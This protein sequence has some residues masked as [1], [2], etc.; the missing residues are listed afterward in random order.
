MINNRTWKF[1]I[2]SQY[3]EF[4]FLKVWENKNIFIIDACDHPSFSLKLSWNYCDVLSNFEMLCQPFDIIINVEI[5]VFVVEFDHCLVFFNLDNFA[6]LTFE[7]SFYQ[8]DFISRRKCLYCDSKL[9]IL[10]FFFFE[11]LNTFICN[12]INWILRNSKFSNCI[13]VWNDIFKFD[14]FEWEPFVKEPK[15]VLL[16]ESVFIS[17]LSSIKLQ[18]SRRSQISRFVFLFR[19]FFFILSRDH[20]NKHSLLF[21]VNISNLSKVSFVRILKNLNPLLQRNLNF[22]LLL[23]EQIWSF[24]LVNLCNFVLKEI[25]KSS[26]SISNMSLFKSFYINCVGNIVEAAGRDDQ[27]SI[28]LSFQC[29]IFVDQRYT[30]LFL[31]AN[32]HFDLP[33]KWVFRGWEKSLIM[34]FCLSVWYLLIFCLSSSF[35]LFCKFVVMLS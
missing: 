26:N 1:E 20:S 30:W 17:R 18:L 31:S 32:S 25:F 35:I 28:M 8:N 11:V 14:V 6:G 33:Q 4:S 23:C 10:G 13:K 7:V 34:N 21:S 19:I 27:Q 15:N 5:D 29:V 24:L 12:I 2:I 3:L 22:L 9:I 16:L